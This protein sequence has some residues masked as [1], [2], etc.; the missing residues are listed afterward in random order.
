MPATLCELYVVFLKCSFHA[1]S[2][3]QACSSGE[4]TLTCCGKS[5]SNEFE[6]CLK[7]SEKAEQITN[8]RRS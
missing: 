4:K 7:Y 2:V 8:V 6:C 3:W 1:T 5:V